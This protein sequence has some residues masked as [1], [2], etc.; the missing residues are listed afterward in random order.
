VLVRHATAAKNL[1]SILARGLLTRYAKGRLPAV[2]A[3]SPHLSWWAVIHV[4][5]R[6]GGRTETTV[7]LAHPSREGG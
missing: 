4:V 2:W 6:H 1:R 7:V 5:R 3:A